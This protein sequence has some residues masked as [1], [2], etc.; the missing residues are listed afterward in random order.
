MSLNKNICSISLTSVVTKSLITFGIYLLCWA[1]VI[2]VVTCISWYQ[3]VASLKHLFHITWK[4]FRVFSEFKS[5][6]IEHCAQRLATNCTEF[7]HKYLTI[8][9][10]YSW[11][12]IKRILSFLI[13][14]YIK[15]KAICKCC[16]LAILMQHFFVKWMSLLERTI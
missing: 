13:S 11:Y 5:K 1:C 14:E 9:S 15:E 12:Q 10:L 4:L 6:L 16:L 2:F 7:V 8:V 3:F